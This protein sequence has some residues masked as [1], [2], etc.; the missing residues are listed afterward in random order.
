M[1]TGLRLKLAPDA[2]VGA[3]SLRQRVASYERAFPECPGSLWVA[4]DQDQWL[5]GVWQ[6]GA[7][8]QNATRYYGAYPHSYL[9]RIQALFPEIDLGQV[10]HVFSGSLP[11][12]PYTRCDINIRLR[13]ELVGN[14]Y[15]LK[16]LTSR[17]FDLALA[18]PPYTP[19]DAKEYGTSG[20]DRGL[21]TNAIADVVKVGGFLVWL[22]TTWP[23]HRKDLWR[24][25]GSI[26]V[27]RSTNHRVR[28]VSLFQR[29]S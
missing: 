15:N 23:M 1:T 21:A 17:T 28:A 18:D 22:D 27:I 5:Y 8:Y 20:I 7:Q 12:G 29:K 6:I 4:G 2:K 3:L 24:Y 13:P 9:E 10:L 25:F 14:V 11:P 26:Q 16:K 19:E